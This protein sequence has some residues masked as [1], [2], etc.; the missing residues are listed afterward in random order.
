MVVDI[1]IVESETG[2]D[3]AISFSPFIIIICITHVGFKFYYL[4]F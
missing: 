4:R 3:V 1:C 2:P